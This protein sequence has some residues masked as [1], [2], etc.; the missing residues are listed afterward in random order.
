MQACDFAVVSSSARIGD[1]HANYDQVPGGGSTQ[2]LP[3]LVGR[4]RATGLILSGERLSGEDAAAWGLAYRSYEPAAFDTAVEAL[5]ERLAKVAPET[6]A[7]TK[8][9]IREGLRE[10]LAA[11]LAAERV[12][13][14]E[15]IRGPVG[16]RAYEEFNPRE[17]DR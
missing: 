14:V 7:V 12:A 1:N 3:R 11:G 15:H 2:R 4:Q 16:G 10:D 17:G 5:A 13:A 8:R 9:L 6:L